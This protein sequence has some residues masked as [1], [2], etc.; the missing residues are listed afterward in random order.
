MT[1]VTCNLWKRTFT[2]TPLVLLLCFHRLRFE[3]CLQYSHQLIIYLL[4]CISSTYIIVLT[5]CNIFI[6]FIVM[7]WLFIYLVVGFEH[8]LEEGF[9]EV[10]SGVVLLGDMMEDVVCV[11]E[12]LRGIW[13]VNTYISS[14]ATKCCFISI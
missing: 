10:E 3:V 12:G 14:Y 8:P 13:K 9:H 6:Y 4:V 1:H 7:L 5:L 11:H 2:L